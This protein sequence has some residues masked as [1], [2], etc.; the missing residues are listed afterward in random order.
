MQPRIYTYKVTFE[1]I[2]HWY[3]GVHKEKKYGEIYLG[4]PVTHKWMWDFYT[5]EIQSLEVFP[6]TD[7]G[8]KEAQLVEDRLILPDLNNPLCLNE[9]VGNIKSLAI[10]RKNGEVSGKKVHERKNSEGKSIRGIELAELAHKEKT[11]EG[12]SKNA[13]KAGKSVPR[14]KQRIKGKK[15]HEE[16]NEEGKS[17]HWE[18]TLGKQHN[19]KDEQGRS[20]KAMRSLQQLWKCLETGK[21]LPPGPLTHWQRH[22]GI[23]T[24][25]RARVK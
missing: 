24:S 10:L 11:P 19:E 9:A 4:S 16:K 1:E 17:T 18:K 15:T 25:L 6:F 21:V 2:P 20:L 5:P 7:E 8:W 14:E 3:W 23:D 13:V 12:K 22:R